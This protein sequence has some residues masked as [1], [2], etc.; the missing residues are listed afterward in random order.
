MY[1]P[2]GVCGI[3]GRADVFGLGGVRIIC[4]GAER[5]DTRFGAL[6][7]SKNHSTEASSS[8]SKMFVERLKT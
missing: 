1:L 2:C 8:L 6:G 3:L 7:L 4:L 5:K